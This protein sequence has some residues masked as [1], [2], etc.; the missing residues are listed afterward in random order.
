LTVLRARLPALA[1]AA[2]LPLLLTLSAPTLAQRAA[3][4]PPDWPCVQRLIPELT[5][6][7]IWTG[8]PIDGLET[9]WWDDGELARVVRFS[10]ARET[11][12][13]AAVERVEEYIAGLD[14][15]EREEQLTLLFA[16]LFQ[17]LGRE[18]SRTIEAVR[19]YS[20]GQVGQLEQISTLVDR[21]EEARS[22]NDVPP[23]DVERL[24]QELFWQRRV[25]QDRQGSLRA[26]CQQ[27]Y[28]LEERLG[29]LVRVITAN[30][31]T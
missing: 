13:E 18:R 6:A 3:H 14:E 24:E 7:T 8:P 23:E 9:D 5:A 25:F 30:L 16:G 26:L 19:R 22:G 11:S 31:P 12:P 2:A 20:R 28:L 15:D 27:P 1:V 21:L 10:A 29:R 17:E 4:G